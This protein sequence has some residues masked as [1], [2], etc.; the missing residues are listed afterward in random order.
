M[1]SKRSTYSVEVASSDASRPSLVADA[2]EPGRDGRLNG[3]IEFQN[4]SDQ[5]IEVSADPSFAY[6]AG[7]RVAKMP[8]GLDVGGAYSQESNADPFAWYARH[9]GVGAATKSLR[10]HDS[11]H[12]TVT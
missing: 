11:R 3:R 2:A 10:V 6:G 4:N 9:G 8:V 12:P 5:T 7:L 1:A